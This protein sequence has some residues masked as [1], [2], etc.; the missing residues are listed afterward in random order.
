MAWLIW[1]TRGYWSLLEDALEDAVWAWDFSHLV[2]GEVPTR[3]LLARQRRK[4]HDRRR[5]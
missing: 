2:K 4:Q 1:F 5:A 3:R